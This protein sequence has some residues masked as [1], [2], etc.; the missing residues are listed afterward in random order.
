[1]LDFDATSLY[2]S[3]MLDENSVYCKIEIGFSLKLRMKDVY[4]EAIKNEIFNQYGNE[5]AIL[6]IKYYIAHDITFQ[7]LPVKE[8]FKNIEVN[9]MKNCF[10]IDTLT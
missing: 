6:K 3:A 4:V 9:R 10:I 1:M 8:E 2:P 5:N 7:H